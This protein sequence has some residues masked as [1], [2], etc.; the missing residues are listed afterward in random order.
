MGDVKDVVQKAK[1][2]WQSKTIIGTV[3]MILPTII[4]LIFP[5]S[6]VDVQGAIDEA[7]S[8][9]DNVAEFAD[10]AWSSILEIVGFVVAVYGR[11]KAKV[12]IKKSLV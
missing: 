8:I 9:A 5:E 2:W 3:L 1:A 10:S 7:W 4:R 6:E 11:I 12:G